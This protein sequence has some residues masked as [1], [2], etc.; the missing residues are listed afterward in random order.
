MRTFFTSFDYSGDGNVFIGVKDNGILSL[1]EDLENHLTFIPNTPSWRR[2]TNDNG[3]DLGIIASQAI[4]I[5]N[6]GHLVATSHFGTLYYNGIDYKNYI[7]SSY[8]KYYS[9]N[10]ETFHSVSLDYFPGEH[11]PISIVEKDNG[12]LIYCNSGVFPGSGTVIELNHQ[13]DSLLKY[14]NTN[15]IIDVPE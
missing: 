2:H 13:N 11:F 1:D 6:S 4:T 3:D 10:S 8:Y 15:N 12:N 7:P 5:T 14:D 9:G